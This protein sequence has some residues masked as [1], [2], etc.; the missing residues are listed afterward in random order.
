MTDALATAP[1]PKTERTAGLLKSLVH[2]KVAMFLAWFALILLLKWPTLTQPPVWDGSMSV[3]PA[4][5]TLAENNFDL[6]YLLDQPGYT[7]GGPNVH[8]LSLVTWLT[9]FVIGAI[10][11]GPALFPVLHLLHFAIA[12]VTMVALYRFATP[13][14]TRHLAAA[15]TLASLTFPLVLTQS[16]YL[17]L[18]FPLLA[19]T[20]LAMLMWTRRRIGLVILWVSIAVLVK[21]SGIIVAAA[22]AAATVLESSAGRSRFR[23]G[24]LIMGVPTALLAITVASSPGFGSSDFELHALRMAQ[25]LI[26]VPDL[27]FLI[28]AYLLAITICA[29]GRRRVSRTDPTPETWVVQRSQHAIAF[30]TMTFFLFYVTLPLAGN[31]LIVVPRYYVQVVPFIMIGLVS[32]ASHRISPNVV[33]VVVLAFI[34]WSA[35]NRNGDFYPDN[36]INNF[37]LIE[38]SGAYADLAQLQLTEIR[39]LEELPTD[40]AV[41]YD[42]PTSIRLSYP[43]LGYADGPLANGRNIAQETTLRSGNLR[44]FPK[45]FYLLYE[46]P[47]LGGDIIRSVWQQA[48][49]DPTRKVQIQL[50]EVAQFQ[51]RLIH[52]TSSNVP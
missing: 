31:A 48:E 49:D 50:L 25:Y 11:D 10:G 7:E 3:F 32:L 42:Q 47:W 30:L 26:R 6:S 23:S 39:A 27:V 14:L 17:Y 22:L 43:L 38:R 19:A 35:A 28:F 13:M 44:D 40:V 16:G 29:F 20:A 24:L 5:I 34:G 4:A 2:S 36:N 46:Y 37:P 52:I 45:D 33:L 18:E 12:A 9:A 1:T 41:F 51:S 15:V 21:G 8:G